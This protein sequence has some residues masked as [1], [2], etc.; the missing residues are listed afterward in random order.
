MSTKEVLKEF[1]EEQYQN[2]SNFILYKNKQLLEK[3]NY[4]EFAE[5]QIKKAKSIFFSAF[6]GLIICSWYSI[7]TLIKFGASSDWFE[8]AVGLMT[9][10]ATIVAI[11]YATKEYYKIK[12][13]MSFF[14]KLIEHSETES[15]SILNTE[16]VEQIIE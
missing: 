11:F 15:D 2:T 1:F 16:P 7:T 3:G 4:R 14:I 5:E 10:L 12:S 6:G 13:S 9:W 8:L